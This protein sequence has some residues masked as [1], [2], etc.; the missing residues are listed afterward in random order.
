MWLV[1]G[2]YV[3]PYLVI[4]LSRFLAKGWFTH[5]I[6]RCMLLKIPTWARFLFRNLFMETLSIVLCL[7]NWQ[8]VNT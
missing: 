3:L 4:A 8:E 2:K 5:S 7:E 6:E 1:G